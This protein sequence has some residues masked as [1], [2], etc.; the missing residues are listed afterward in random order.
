[1]INHISGNPTF[2]LFGL[3]RRCGI[4]GYTVQALAYHRRSLMHTPA[5]LNKAVGFEERS[6]SLIAVADLQCPGRVAKEPL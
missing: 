2:S 3:N 5:G 6:A 1:M 4:L